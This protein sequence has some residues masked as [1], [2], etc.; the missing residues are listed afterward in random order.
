MSKIT[1]RKRLLGLFALALVMVYVRVRT[2]PGLLA[3]DTVRYRGVDAYY[4][5]RHVNYAVQHWPHTLSYDV[6]TNFPYGNSPGQFGTPYD[7][8][9]ATVAKFTPLSAEITLFYAPV[10]LAVATLLVVYLLANRLLDPLPALLAAAVFALQPGI[11]LQRSLAGMSDHH[12]AETLLMALSLLLVVGM[13]Q[14]R[15]RRAIGYA[16]AAAAVT[17][18]YLLVWPPGLLL[19]GIYAT[20]FWLT[21]SHGLRHD[22]PPH[23]PSAVPQIVFFAVLAALLAPFATVG[24]SVTSVSMLHV[25]GPVGAAGVLAA[26]AWLCST[27]PRR[28]AVTAATALPLGLGGLYVF[29]PG[30]V[31][32][33]RRFLFFGSDGKIGETAGWASAYGQLGLTPLHAVTFMYGASVLFA[34]VGLVYVHLREKWTSSVRVLLAVWALL[35]AC[36]AVTQLRFHYYFVLPV[37]VYAGA[38]VQGAL[39]ALPASRNGR[40]ALARVLLLLVLTLSVPLAQAEME[41]DTR[42][43]ENWQPAL[44]YLQEE[45]REPTVAYHGTYERQDDFEYPEGSYGVLSWWD[46]GHWITVLAERPAVTNPHQQQ[47]RTA[48][49]YFLATN[50]TEAQRYLARMGDDNAG[51]RYI[52][53]DE[54]MTDPDS[55]LASIAAY[56]P[57]VEMGDLYRDGH[58]TARYNESVLHQLRARDTDRWAQVYSQRN[59][60]IYRRTP[61]VEPQNQSLSGLS[62]KSGS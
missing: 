31:W 18:V 1:R 60:T 20:G 11:Y 52:V 57:T 36:A 14:S 12:A 33:A 26:S 61:A 39:D 42:E 2:A 24:V 46:Y 54:S 10:L 40:H 29:T 59:V 3:G 8:A 58:Y 15:V 25:A 41:P 35:L 17:G 47:A 19:I 13:L 62:E 55:R 51:V 44:E 7:L 4:H 56:H 28:Y 49:Q 34:L 27:S 48:A 21:V 6:Y 16:V 23:S 50:Q 43:L 37:A 53:L 30:L 45:T 5:L 22:T 9:V 38:A 32:R